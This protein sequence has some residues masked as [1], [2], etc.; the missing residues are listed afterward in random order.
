VLIVLGSL[1]VVSLVVVQVQLVM[2]L[3][4]RR[5]GQLPEVA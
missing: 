4:R 3:K 5:S 2:M 1:I